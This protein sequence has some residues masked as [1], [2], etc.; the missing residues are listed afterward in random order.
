MMEWQF[1]T[2]LGSIFTAGIVGSWFARG[3]LEGQFNK[4]RENAHAIL[5]VHERKDDERHRETLKAM[6]EMEANRRASETK[7]A[8]RVTA[9]EV[10]LTAVEVTLAAISRE[11]GKYTGPAHVAGR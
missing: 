3:Y 6:S 4:T 1:W 11:G 10:R 2:Q 7:S 8:E 5:D 9:I